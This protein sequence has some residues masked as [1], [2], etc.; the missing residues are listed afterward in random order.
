MPRKISNALTTLAV[1]NAKPGR[2]ADGGGLYLLVKETGSRSWVYRASIGGKVRDIGLGPAWG[3]D[4]VSLAA[5]RDLARDKAREAKA[6]VVLVSDRRKQALEAK[7]AAQ[8]AKVAGTTFR[9]AADA[10][11]TL[12]EDSWRNEKH[13]AQWKATLETYAYPHFGDMMVADIGTEHVMA[14]LQ[15]IWRTK[16]ETA[17]RL[18][19][20]IENVLDAAKVQGLRSGENPARWRGHLDQ[21]LPKRAKHTLGHH[22]A[23]AYAELPTF[24]ADLREREAVAGMALEFTILTA[25]RSGETLGATWAE[26]DLDNALWVIPAGRM[27][28]GREHRVPLSPRVMEI[29]K[30]VK[31]L[32]KKGK[33]TAPVFP[34]QGDDGL[35]QMAMAMLMRRMGQSVTAHGFRSTFRDWASETT[36]FAHE[37]CEMAL[38]HTIANKAEAAY[39]R[40][41]LFEKRRKLMEAWAVYCATP[42]SAGSNV[43]PI[44]ETS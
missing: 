9:D 27:K 15:P 17:S 16:A 41:D 19:G 36:A 31:G 35:S 40:G 13:R 23:M 6:G 4:A 43:T 8:A 24:M 26:I 1:K 14:A 7:A 22:A 28:A 10:Y 30:E 12:R 29:L 38:A 33:A 25:A 18:R 34:G 39:R 2:H 20:R 37:V 3:H 11:M 5:A 21:V 44:R 42:V 32:N